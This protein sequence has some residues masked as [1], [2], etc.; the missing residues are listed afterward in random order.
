MSNIS[1]SHFCGGGL[2]GIENK[3]MNS[4]STGTYQCPVYMSY[5]GGVGGGHIC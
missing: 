2:G 1:D 4:H 3:E 5:L